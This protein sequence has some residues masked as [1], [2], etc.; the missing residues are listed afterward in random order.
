VVIGG[1][2]IVLNPRR[3]SGI[4]TARPALYEHVFGGYNL[5]SSFDFSSLSVLS[6]VHVFFRHI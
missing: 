6:V 5:S 1:L 3:L 2:I 4:A